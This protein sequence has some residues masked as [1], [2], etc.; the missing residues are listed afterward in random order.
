MPKWGVCYNCMYEQRS[1]NLFFSPYSSIAA[2][3]L[4]RT[5]RQRRRKNLTS[6]SGKVTASPARYSHFKCHCDIVQW[7][8]NSQQKRLLVAL[9][10]LQMVGP[11]RCWVAAA[12][13]DSLLAPRH[14]MSDLISQH[15]RQCHC[16][17]SAFHMGSSACQS[18]WNPSLCH[19]T[20]C[21]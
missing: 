13:G 21:Y 3:R 15:Q 14:Q 7:P 10:R 5:P 17:H 20:L 9:K 19:W 12:M 6:A 1:L 16:S 4:P 2:L 8:S 11:V 18:F